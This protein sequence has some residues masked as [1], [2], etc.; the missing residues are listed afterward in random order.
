MRRRHWAVGVFVRDAWRGS[1]TLNSESSRAADARALL[2]NCGSDLGAIQ[3]PFHPNS[4]SPIAP[5]FVVV[6]FFTE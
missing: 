5:A 2:S 6:L 3:T 1:E 4:I